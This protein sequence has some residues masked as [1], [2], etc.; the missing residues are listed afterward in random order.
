MSLMSDA[1]NFSQNF[2][3]KEPNDYFHLEGSTEKNYSKSLHA[4]CFLQVMIKLL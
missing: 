3:E 1:A 2:D 4:C